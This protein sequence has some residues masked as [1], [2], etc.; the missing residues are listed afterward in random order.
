MYYKKPEK[1]RLNIR[2]KKMRSEI[3]ILYAYNVNICSVYKKK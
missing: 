1:S 2:D 3:M